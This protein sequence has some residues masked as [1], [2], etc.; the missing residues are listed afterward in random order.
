MTSSE[1]QPL[2]L[3]PGPVPASLRDAFTEAEASRRAA[4]PQSHPTDDLTD[5]VLVD[6]ADDEARLTV[7]DQLLG[8][9]DG[10]ATLAYLVAARSSSTEAGG[11]ASADPLSPIVPLPVGT[12]S[13]A[14]RRR[15]ITAV[16]KPVL[17]AA[18]LMLVAGTSW[19][20]FTLPPTADV[21]RT[22]GSAVQLLAVPPASATAP[23]TLAWKRIRT[24]A[25]YR[26]EVL[27]ATDAPVFARETN[28][29]SAVVPAGT[30]K[31]GTYRWWVRSR[32]LDGTEIRSRVEKLTVR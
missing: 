6:S 13:A 20:V 17:L 25:R 5:L 11:N 23:I 3:D 15:R 22:A 10:I 27:D 14:G 31:P 28:D 2:P 24:T 19:Y 26:V 1:S 16:L 7:I 32:S 8:S 30:L 12:N 21:V 18:S 29:S 4:S 9:R